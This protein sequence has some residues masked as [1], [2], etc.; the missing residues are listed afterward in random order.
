MTSTP[1]VGTLTERNLRILIADED[2]S[3]LQRLG[4]VLDGLGHEVAPFVVSVQEATE[5]I[6]REDPD[7]AIVV[8][9]EDD[10]HAMALIGEAVEFA[11]GP[12]LAQLGNCDE[13]FAARAAERGISAYIA[14]INPAE[15]Q[16]AIEVAVRRYREAALLN[17]RVEQLETALQ[18]RVIIERA[19]GVLMERHRIDDRA[20]FQR[21]REHARSNN[22]RVVDVA[23]ALLEGH[24]LT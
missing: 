22:R 23:A 12:V 24:A 1:A 7:L 21:L 15:V 20:A 6:V 4:D 18:R 2:E 14:S 3:A 13:D 10:E 9:H 8:V 16:A 19:K 17:E 5:L 11:R